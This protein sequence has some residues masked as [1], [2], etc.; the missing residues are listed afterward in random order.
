[1]LF[2]N[3]IMIYDEIFSNLI[4]LLEKIALEGIDPKHKKEK[5]EK[6]YDYIVK[7]CLEYIHL[8]GVDIKEVK[9]KMDEFYFKDFLQFFLRTLTFYGNLLI[10]SKEGYFKDKQ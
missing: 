1:M 8:L 5:S 6:I 7:V 10:R 2:G 9:N 4:N 3:S